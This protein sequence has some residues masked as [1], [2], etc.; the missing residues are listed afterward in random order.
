[1]AKKTSKSTKAN[2][3]KNTSDSTPAITKKS[4]GLISKKK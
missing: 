2:S 4:N 1:M 3:R